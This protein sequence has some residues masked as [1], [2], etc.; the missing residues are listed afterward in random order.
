MYLWTDSQSRKLEFNYMIEYVSSGSR[1]GTSTTAGVGGATSANALGFS[2]LYYFYPEIFV[3]GSVDKGSEF[4]PYIGHFM[5]DPPKTPTFEAT[6]LYTLDFSGAVNYNLDKMWFF[7]NE[8]I[9]FMAS[10]RNADRSLMESSNAATLRMIIYSGRN[11]YVGMLKVKMPAG[12]TND[13]LGVAAVTN[14][15]VFYAWRKKLNLV[16]DLIGI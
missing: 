8:K 2:C 7:D 12:Y 3:G 14:K 10:P 1:M 5:M 16:T 13:I 15:I 11:N 9:I 6:K 4:V